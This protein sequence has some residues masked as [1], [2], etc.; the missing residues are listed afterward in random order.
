MTTSTG[1][2]RIPSAWNLTLLAQS[3]MSVVY[4]HVIEYINSFVPLSVEAREYISEKMYQQVL[5]KNTLLHCADEVCDKVYFIEKGLVRW[6]YYNEDGKDVT[7]S[8]ALENS[9][10]TAFDSFSQRKPSRYSI[11]LLEDS[12]VHSM[13]YAEIEIELETFPETQRLTNLILVQILEQMLEKNTALQ[14]KNAK[15]RYRFMNEKQ[16]QI[17][18]RVS[19]GN[20]ASYLGITQETL[21]RI[22]AKK[23]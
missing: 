9:F 22:R 13:T 17:L 19:L 16:S 11:E 23:I 7:D 5:P 6:F 3:P 14:F 18:Q 21:S 2:N 15:E 8:F 12:I 20:I 4:M 10:V 1:G